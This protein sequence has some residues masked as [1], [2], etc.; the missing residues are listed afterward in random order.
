MVNKTVYQERAAQREAEAT[1][2]PLNLRQR[3]VIALERIATALEC[4]A[5]SKL[6]GI[7]LGALETFV[8]RLEALD[9]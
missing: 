2:E 6:E 3:E 4:F 5:Q 1:I 8:K 9:E 7:V